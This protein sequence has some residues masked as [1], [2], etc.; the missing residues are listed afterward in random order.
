MIDPQRLHTDYLAH[1]AQVTRGIG[2]ALGKLGLDSVVLHSGSLVKRTRFDDQYWPLR[3]NPHFAHLIPLEA[4]DSA[5]VIVPGARPKLVHNV[6]RD[7]WDGAA[8][9]ADVRVFEAF[10][11]VRVDGVDAVQTQLPVPTR[12]AFVGDDEARARAWG[13]DATAVNPRELVR[14]LDALRVL[15]SAY[16]KACLAEA[17]RRASFGHLKV[18]DAFM[19][20]DPSEL[21]LHLMFLARTAQDDPETPYKNIVALDAHAATLHHVHYSRRSLPAQSLLLDAGATFRGYASDITRTYVKGKGA[22]ASAFSGLV[23]GMESMQ[24]RL[25]AEVAVGLRYEALHNRAHEHLGELLASLGVIRAS[26]DELVATGATRWFLPHGLGHSLGLCCHD[27]GCAEEKPSADNPFLRTTI[28]IA[29]DQC[30]TIEPGCYFIPEK[31]AL[32]RSSPLNSQADWPLID[33]LAKLGGVRIEDDVVVRAGAPVDNLTRAV[34][35]A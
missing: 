6:A 11:V 27:V 7:Y 2:E 30:F 31:M 1:V 21:D 19:A 9:I 10:D 18:R 24:Q 3:L 26:A 15:K 25:C 13:F 8:P 28:T 20:G 32:L 34:L 22:A 33:A 12:S 16:E 17:N 14:A 4:P 23:T 29:P 35:P 5:I